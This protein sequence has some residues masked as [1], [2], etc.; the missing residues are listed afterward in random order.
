ML[1]LQNW[2]GGLNHIF[3]SLNQYCTFGSLFNLKEKAAA[4]LCLIAV[5]AYPQVYEQ[6]LK[7]WLEFGINFCKISVS[8]SFS[9]P[10]PTSI[11]LNNCAFLQKKIPFITNYIPVSMKHGQ[12]TGP[13]GPCARL[14][15]G[16]LF[17]CGLIQVSFSVVQDILVSAESS[18][19]ITIGP[20]CSLCLLDGK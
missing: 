8:P 17:I 13:N 11:N 4:A 16:H 1:W 19:I 10:H 20:T 7:S 15:K 18:L 12:K 2:Y 6:F 3:S 9:F 14:T 5:L